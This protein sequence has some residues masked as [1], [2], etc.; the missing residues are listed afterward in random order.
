MKTKIL[1]LLLGCLL[2]AS[3]GEDFLTRDLDKSRPNATGYYNTKERADQALT[4]AYGALNGFN[5]GFGRYAGCFHYLNG[6]EFYPTSN[7]IGWDLWGQIGLYNIQPTYN[8]VQETWATFYAGATRANVAIQEMTSAQAIDSENFT[9]AELDVMLGQAYLIRAWN[10]YCLYTWFPKDKLVL[11]DKFL[12]EPTPL[13]PSSA[14]EIFA[15][16]KTDLEMAQ[17]LLKNSLNTTSG[18]AKERVTRGTAAALL[19]KLYMAE[20]MYAEAAAEFAKILPGS[21][22]SYG[23]Y[24][25]VPYRDNFTRNTPNNAESILEFQFKDTGD[26]GNNIMNW[27]FHNFTMNRHAGTNFWWNFALN[28]RHIEEFEYW[29]EGNTKVYDYRAYHSIWGVE[30]GANFT[31]D[32]AGGKGV[33]N[34]RDQKWQLLDGSDAR[35][36][37]IENVIPG[38]DGSLGLRK[39]CRD[40]ESDAYSD[41]S[42]GVI[43]MRI[44]RLGDI[45]LLNAECMAN[46]NP[47]NVDPT[48]RNSA[49]YWVD[50]IR[51]RANQP[52]VGDQEHLYSARPGVL[53]Q[54]PKAADLMTAKGWTTLELV[55]HERFVEGLGEGWRHEDLVRWK[56]GVDFDPDMRAAKPGW[57]GYQ[58]IILPVPQVEINN[59]P[60]MPR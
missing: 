7:G 50:M 47:G 49:L 5:L 29:M 42:R 20:G 10:Y 6:D 60:G 31:E 15:F 59:N 41:T 40:V 57:Q 9:Q 45:I 19:G 27:V 3:C 55:K 2:F 12:V 24:S 58:S 35:K 13:A 21:D 44:I 1:T 39:Y 28:P 14:A 36:D 32:Q 37:S 51:N 48:D 56:V 34:W 54:L 17:D 30:N 25:L 11:L 23:T 18:Y 46:L 26:T 43:N 4:A 38:R 16:I 8:E 53:G 22:G 52:A 33:V